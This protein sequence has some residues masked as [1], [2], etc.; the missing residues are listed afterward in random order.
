MTV[1]EIKAKP[2]GKKRNI[3]DDITIVVMDLT[4]QVK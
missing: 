4:D 1:S 2:Q 3:H